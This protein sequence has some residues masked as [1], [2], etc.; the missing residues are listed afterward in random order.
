[1][2][3]SSPLPLNLRNFCISSCLVQIS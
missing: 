3:F 2:L 1:L